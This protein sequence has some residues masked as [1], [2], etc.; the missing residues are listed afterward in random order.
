LIWFKLLEIFII[1]EFIIQVD[2]DE[3]IPFLPI[4][5]IPYLL[6]FV[7]IFFGCLYTGF[8]SKENFYKLIFFL[9]AGM[10]VAYII[11]MIFPNGQN[12]RTAPAQAQNDVF[13]ALIRLIHATDSSTNVCPSVH[14]I[15]AFAVDAALRHTSPFCKKRVLR[16][17]S[18]IFFI[19]VCMSTVFTKQHSIFDVYCGLL[20][21][22][23]I[24]IP[25]YK[26]ELNWPARFGESLRQN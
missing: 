23:L 14:V 15:N 6:W 8:K 22:G 20:V 3:Y 12:L 24:Y 1:P 26:L 9:G 10:A 21:G 25:L 19:L 2:L 13:S 17:L 16:Y 4:F 5:V 7:Y 18:F 11:Y